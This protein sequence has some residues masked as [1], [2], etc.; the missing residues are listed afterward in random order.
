MSARYGGSLSCKSNFAVDEI[1]DISTFLVMLGIE[2]SK[3]G[4]NQKS[5]FSFLYKIRF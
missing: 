2:I 4:K 1:V 5:S 3:L